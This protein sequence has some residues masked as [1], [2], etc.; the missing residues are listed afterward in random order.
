MI[1]RNKTTLENKSNHSYHELR[2]FHHVVKFRI[3]FSGEILIFI[4]ISLLYHQ[5]WRVFLKKLCN[6]AVPRAIKPSSALPWQKQQWQGVIFYTYY[7]ALI[8]WLILGFYVI[9]LKVCIETNG[10]DGRQLQSFSVLMGVNHFLWTTWWNYFNLPVGITQVC[11]SKMRTN[12]FLNCL[13]LLSLSHHNLCHPSSYL[14][15]HSVWNY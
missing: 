15:T 13:G 2:D 7:L 6:P 8:V 3:S 11:S 1:K 9:F 12:K 4:T 14:S 10:N 5:S